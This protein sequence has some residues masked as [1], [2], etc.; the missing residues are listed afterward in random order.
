M[1]LLSVNVGLPR[2]VEWRG[3]LVRTSIFKAPVEGR[4]RVGRLN[5]Q[6]DQQSDLSVHGGRDK[7]VYAYPS[8]HYALWKA[9]LP[10]A[11]LDWGAFGENFTIEGLLEDRV[12][13]GDQLRC[14]TAA[15]V[16]T[17]PRTPCF[18]LGIRFGRQDI[19]KRFHRSGRSGFYLAVL[20]EGE[21]GAGDALELIESPGERMSVAEIA[22]LASDHTADPALLRRVSE[23]PALAESWRDHFRGRLEQR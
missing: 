16:V 22:R 14:G 21:V 23:L 2:E 15:F 18:K 3:K 19:V 9:E 7:A 6:G 8:E 4:V 17:Q 10:D 5:L 12:C 20:R 1:K 11:T 13:I